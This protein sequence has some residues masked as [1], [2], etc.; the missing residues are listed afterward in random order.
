MEEMHSAQ[1]VVGG[2]PGAPTPSPGWRPQL[3]QVRATEAEERGDGWW[4]GSEQTLIH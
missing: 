3:P 4:G 2:R 1:G